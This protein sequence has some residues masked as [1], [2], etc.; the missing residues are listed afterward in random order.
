MI[1]GE[2]GVITKNILELFQEKKEDREYL[3]ITKNKKSFI[4]HLYIDKN[5]EVVSQP[6]FLKEAKIKDKVQN[7]DKVIQDNIQQNPD[8]IFL[9]PDGM[10][11]GMIAYQTKPVKLPGHIDD[12]AFMT[13]KECFDWLLLRSIGL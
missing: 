8:R 12:Y 7:K 1:R 6:V 3:R 11:L 9:E 4:V 2:E 13:P 10:T 5:S